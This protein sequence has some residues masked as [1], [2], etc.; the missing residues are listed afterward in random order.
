MVEAQ[1]RCESE[2]V[3]AGLVRTLDFCVSAVAL[4]PIAARLEGALLG[5]KL[6]LEGFLA[7]RSRRSG[8]LV[9][10]VT[11]CRTAPGG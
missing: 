1:L 11:G 3:E 5:S 4:G 7:P 6:E 8:K 10:H 9:L 2:V